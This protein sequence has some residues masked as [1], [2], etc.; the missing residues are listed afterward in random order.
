MRFE[1]TANGV[2]VSVETTCP[3]S[4]DPTTPSKMPGPKDWG[5]FVES[6]LTAAS[7]VPGCSPAATTSAKTSG[8]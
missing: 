6:V 3:T 2:T 4:T 8:K 7:A 5:V 1:F